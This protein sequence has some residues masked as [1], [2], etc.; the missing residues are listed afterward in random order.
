MKQHKRYQTSIILLL[1]CFAFIYKGIRDA[2][3][4]MIVIGVF[5]AIYA[6]IRIVLLLTLS[7]V[8]QQEIAEDSDMTSRYLRA[9]Y[10]RYIEMYILYKKGECEVLY[11]ENDGLLLLSHADDMYYAS[12]KN[13]QAAMDI[14]QLIP[15]DYHGLCVCDDIFMECIDLYI[16]Y[17]TKFNS[18][19]MVYEKQEKA[20]LTNT[21]IRI[22]PLTEKDIEIVKQTYNNPIYDQ[23]GYIASCIRNGMLGAY[24]DDKLA[25]YIGLHNSGAIGLLEVFE[26][27]RQQGIAKTLVASMINH[28]LETKQIAYTQVQQKNETSLQLQEKLGF[29]KADKPCVWIFKKEMETLHE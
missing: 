1:V 16:T 22:Q 20:V 4:P 21:T 12:A 19:N 11:E 7:N 9:N 2:Q 13:K 3:T 10:E 28:C 24:V 17:G 25:G 18:Y 8:A 23:P 26:D 6:T 5:L 14:L 15:Q 27:Y 29:T